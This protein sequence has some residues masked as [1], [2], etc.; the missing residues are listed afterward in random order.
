MPPSSQD[1]FSSSS[2][3]ASFP[4]PAEPGRDG[5]AG[6]DSREETRRLRWT[7]SPLTRRT[8]LA[9]GGLAGV[10]LAAGA[11]GRLISV[12][13]GQDTRFIYRGQAGHFA[14]IEALAWA[15]GSQ[16]SASAA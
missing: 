16:R 15:R 6:G 7:P 14:E 2:E 13:N 3:A 1:D 5:G 8:I 10:G 4:E 11:L 12:L 9:L